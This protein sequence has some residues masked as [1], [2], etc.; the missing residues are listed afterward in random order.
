[1]TRLLL[2]YGEWYMDVSDGTKWYQNIL[3]PRTQS[4][5]D[6][7]VKSRVSQTKNVTGIVK[8]SSSLPA[9]RAF[10]VSMTVN[11]SYGSVPAQITGGGGQLPVITVG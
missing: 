11:T 5:R 6:L 8:Y 4:T 7:E 3:G 9:P 10:S 1:M 2:F